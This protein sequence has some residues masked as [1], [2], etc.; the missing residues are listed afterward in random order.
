MENGIKRNSHPARGTMSSNNQTRREA[1]A[2]SVAAA[3]HWNS[4]PPAQHPPT[5]QMAQWTGQ[6]NPPS[7]MIVTITDPEDQ[8]WLSQVTSSGCDP[9]SVITAGRQR[10]QQHSQAQSPRPPSNTVPQQAQ[11]VS[12]LLPLGK[13]ACNECGD[14]LATFQQVLD[15]YTAEHTPRHRALTHES[16]RQI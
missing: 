1:Q 5:N 14:V 15:H 10:H 8:R 13:V 11:K 16:D 2:R 6:V 4:H 3:D 12:S 9:A 7:P